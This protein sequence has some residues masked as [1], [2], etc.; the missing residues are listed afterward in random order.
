[1]L[2]ALS[3]MAPGHLHDDVLRAALKDRS[4]R[5]RELAADK[6]MIF[7]LTALLGDLEHALACEPEKTKSGLVFSRDLLRD[8]VTM[9]PSE[10]GQIWVSCRR[11]NGDVVSRFV[12][13]AEIERNGLQAIA[14]EILA[15]SVF[16]AE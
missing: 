11:R 16:G 12:S 9:R 5:I 8:G 2:V 7:G 6:I 1:M 10:N 14:R 3:S 4:S 13:S 15:D